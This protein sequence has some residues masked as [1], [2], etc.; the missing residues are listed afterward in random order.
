MTDPH[1]KIAV[2]IP[3]HRVSAFI[4][5]V[6]ADVGPEVERIYVV[7]DACPEGSGDLVESECRDPRV[8]LIRNPVNLGV[9]G[10]V[11]AGFDRAY[12]DGMSVGVKIDGDGQMRGADIERFVRPIRDGQADYAKGNRFYDPTSLSQM[13]W[14]R[15]VGNA[16]MSFVAKISTGYWDV[17]DP[18]NGFIALDLRLLPYLSAD[19]ISRRYFFESDLLFRASLVRARVIDIPMRALYGDEVSGLSGHREAPAFAWGHLRN[20]MKRIGYSY[21]LRGFNFASIEIVLG[22]LGILIGTV[23]SL[24]ALASPAADSPGTVVGAIA[25]L[26]TGLLLLLGAVH[27]DIQSVPR[28]AIGPLLPDPESPEGDAEEASA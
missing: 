5:G 12:R 28:I 15:I 7:D 21:F 8:V 11:L 22:L 27:H 20:F 9:G 16:A 4:L 13:P 1:F 26:L 18:T 10:A 25:P 3:A 2:I 17:F 6:I 23:L 14:P 19:R 24:Q